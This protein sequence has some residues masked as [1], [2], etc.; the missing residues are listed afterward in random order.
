MKNSRQIPTINEQLE[1]NNSGFKSRSMK[2]KRTQRSAS[3][4]LSKITLFKKFIP[5][6]SLPSID[7]HGMMI[8]SDQP[9]KSVTSD[10]ENNFISPS[11]HSSTKTSSTRRKLGTIKSINN[12]TNIDEHRF[13]NFYGE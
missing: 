13:E 9:M 8:N 5:R 11:N 2:K 3:L 7:P 6:K 1:Q 12:D 4:T 10:N